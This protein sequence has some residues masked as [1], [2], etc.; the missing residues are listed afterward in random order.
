MA[1]KPY[2]SNPAT[3]TTGGFIQGDAVPNLTTR[4]IKAATATNPSAAPIALTVHL[5]PGGANA[6][7]DNMLI[8]SRAIAPGESYTCPELINQGMGSGGTVQAFGN[9]LTF[10]YTAT[11]F[12]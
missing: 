8:S 4:V 6:R 1:V 5:V 10:K 9:G 11:D 7:N 12:V 2:S 3:L